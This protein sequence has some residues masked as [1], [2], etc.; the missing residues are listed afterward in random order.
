MVT[1]VE[2]QQ[3]AEFLKRADIRTMKKDLKV[4][5]EFDAQGERNKIAQLKTLE[6]QLIERKKSDELAQAK[7]VAEKIEMKDV[8]ERESGEERI[9]EKDLKSYAT[10]AEKQQIFLFESNR[11]NLDSQIAEIDQKKEPSL[12]LKKNSLLIQ[13]QE[14]EKNLDLLLDGEKTLE[15][16]QLLIINKQKTTT[17]DSQRKSLEQERSVLESKMEETE[18][19]RWAI[20]KT[21]EEIN[22]QITEVDKLIDALLIKRNEI[23]DKI[24]GIDKSLREV[25]SVIITREEEKRRGLAAEQIARK[26]ALA[27]I[28]EN[29]NENIQ[30]KQWSPLL[31]SKK[32]VD[33]MR[34]LENVPRPVKRILAES[35]K[36]EEAERQQFLKDVENFEK[37]EEQKSNPQTSNIPSPPVKIN[38]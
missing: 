4:L 11:L 3:V 5:R 26:E 34:S 13:K 37:A 12:K 19:K 15:N 38:K 36:K 8:L 23:R 25:Y 14:Q 24:L 35:I 1:T 18:K 20:E 22:F 32:G 29:E 30:R 2:E 21:I 7:A 17:I 33:E 28:R 10:E 31:G 27:K 6:E 9:A 16:E